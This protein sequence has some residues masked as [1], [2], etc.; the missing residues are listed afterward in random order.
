MQDAFILLLH[1]LAALV[2]IYLMYDQHRWRKQRL[3][4]RGEERLEARAAH[5][6]RGERLFQ[7]AV[8]VVI[9]GFSVSL[10][11]GISAGETLFWA[12]LPNHPHG[13]FGPLGLGMFAFLRRKGQLVRD[14]RESGEK[15]ALELQRHGRAGDVIIILMLFHAFLG[16]LYL[17]QLLR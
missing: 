11:R 8:A 2:V 4:L 17:L 12:L 9:I 5:E 13:F 3:E 1:P 10:F 7:A 6:Q 14:Q 15:F 16:F